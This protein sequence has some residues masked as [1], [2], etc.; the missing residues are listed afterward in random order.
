MT[1]D[2]PRYELLVGSETFWRRA[3]S[4]LAAAGSR[5]LVQALTFEGDAT[6]LAVAEAMKRSPARDRR[7][8]VDDF[9]RMV[10]NDSFVRSPRYLTDP[11][12]R[13]E[14]RATA[15]M[16]RALEQCGVGV[17]ITNPLRGNPL[18]Y[19]LRNHK[20]LIVADDVAYIG[21]L[22]FSDHNFDWHDMMLRI[23]G[24]QAADFLAS[25]FQST[26]QGDAR[27]KHLSSGDL[28]LS[29]LDGRTNDA[30][31]VPLFEAIDRATRGIVVVSPYLSF[32]FIDHLGAAARRGIAVEVLTPL[33]NNK[34]LVQNYLLA[35]CERAGAAVRLTAEM[36]HLKAMLIDDSLLVLGSSNFDFPSYYSMEEY[37]A[38][39]R[40]PALAKA[41]E[42][43]V[44]VPMRA[45]AVAPFRPR[46][47]QILAS[48]FLMGLAGL[49]VKRI[50][51]ARRGAARR[52]WWADDRRA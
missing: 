44:L 25:D 41:F 26:W 43:E 11:A 28:D 18:V 46:P 13:A 40:S 29:C 31:F 22:N 36:S 16:F 10:V 9:T 50:G 15:G 24:R 35:A 37:L 21:G 12:F 34:P 38:L 17:R 7:I 23:E 6:G 48:R 33:P 8:L 52:G 45:G 30:G 5:A 14:V 47:R 20:K 4:D 32:P 3:E 51:R 49:V 2:Q 27:L 39:V 19:G 1:G 42:A